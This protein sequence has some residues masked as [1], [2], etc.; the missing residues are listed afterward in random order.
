MMLTRL[1]MQISPEEFKTGNANVAKIVIAFL[2]F[3]EPP[4]HMIPLSLKNRTSDHLHHEHGRTIVIHDS[5][6]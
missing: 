1:Q 3:V 2:F 6:K 5:M 4:L